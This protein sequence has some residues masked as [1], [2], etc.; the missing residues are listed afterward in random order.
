MRQ[1]DVLIQDCDRD[2]RSGYPQKVAKRLAG[3]NL[4]RVPLE[5]RL[6]LAQICRRAGLY[7]MGLKLLN[8]VI[9][10]LP[11]DAISAAEAAEYSALLVR[12]GALSE[13]LERLSSINTADSPEVFLYRAYA[14]FS[15]WQYEA[16]IQSLKEYLKKPL[17]PYARL[18]GQTNLGFAYAGNRNQALALD[19]L[20]DNINLTRE[21]GHQQLQSTCHTLRAQVRLQLG[22]FASAREDLERARN[23]SDAGQTNDNFLATQWQLILKGLESKSQSPFD[24]LR[25][26]AVR[27]HSWEACRMAD[28]YSLQITPNRERFVHLYFGTPFEEFRQIIHKELGPR[29]T[30]P[31]YVL[32]KKSHPRLDLRTGEIDG[33]EGLVF[34][35]KL[36]QLFVALLNDFYQHSRVT[37]LFSQLFPG[38]HF[39][40]ST[41]PTRV[42]QIIWRARD[43][44]K[45]ENIP[46][47]I[48]EDHGFYSLRII[49]AFSFR[50]PIETLSFEI[51][52]RRITQLKEHFGNGNI[53]S[54]RE[55]QRLLNLSKTSTHE[56]IKHA[57]ENGHIERTGESNRAAGY[58]VKK[59]A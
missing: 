36:H 18:I 31:I 50:V 57:I 1:Y 35:G 12:I 30:Q 16:A 52:A 3:L 13:A 32:G 45:T 15:L 53:F 51:P 24:E 26:L 14:H 41:S 25:A 2:I 10:P 29:P 6:P 17:T 11:S 37:A 43:W 49:G 55:A 39:N 22:D 4:S 44:L 47:E 58:K 7:F 21:G 34:G 28:F 40:V 54:A 33:R 5:W 23:L 59:A 9:A 19:V 48:A 56:L 46:L 8:R 38:E 42:H 27:R 20:D